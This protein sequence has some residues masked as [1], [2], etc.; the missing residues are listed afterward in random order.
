MGIRELEYVSNSWSCLTVYIN[1]N[2]QIIGINFT[3]EKHVA[4]EGIELTDAEQYRGIKVL[5]DT[6]RGFDHA[7]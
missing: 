1:T 3:L 2:S 7:E 5:G 4:R 6:R